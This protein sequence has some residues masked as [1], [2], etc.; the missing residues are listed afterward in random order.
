[1]EVWEGILVG[2]LAVLFLGLAVY[3]RKRRVRL[4]GLFFA[5]AAG[6]GSLWPA[7][8]GMTALGC[9]FTVNLF[10]ML[11]AALLGVPGVATLCAAAFFAG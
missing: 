7:A 8:M 4:T 1:M 11:T 6:V 5:T 3:Y 2:I 9:T 10:T